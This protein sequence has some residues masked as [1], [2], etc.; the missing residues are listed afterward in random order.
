MPD[1][2]RH[3]ASQ[4]QSMP[5]AL[6]ARR[7]PAAIPLLFGV[8]VAAVALLAGHEGS[9]PQP[10]GT[11]AHEWAQGPA[12]APVGGAPRSGAAGVGRGKGRT[13]EESGRRR[14]A[15]AQR[16]EARL[17]E[18]LDHLGADLQRGGGGRH[19]EGRQ[20]AAGARAALTRLAGRTPAPK[21][22][23]C[24]ARAR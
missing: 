13:C 14:E 1:A 16:R 7:A 2:T 15:L 21:H 9:M 10:E 20:R 23:Q 5:L 12:R 3:A 11:R 6:P 22:M 19:G 18:Q 8:A 17:I 4:P 24:V